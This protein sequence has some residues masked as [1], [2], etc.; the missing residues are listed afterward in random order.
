MRKIAIPTK[1]DY[2]DGHFGHTDSFSVYNLQDGL[3][4]ESEVIESNKGCGCKSN[5]IEILRQK[6]VSVMLAGNM[7]EGAY[8]KLR[9]A[10][11]EVIRGCRGKVDSVLLK[12]ASGDLK[13]DGSHCQSH[14]HHRHAF[15]G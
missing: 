6:G 2:V 14:E 11:I 3:I 5:I 4:T 7:G 9:A 8:Q 13:D 1:N 10:G 15:S 12:Y